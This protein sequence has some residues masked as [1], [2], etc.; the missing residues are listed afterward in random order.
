MR[1]LLPDSQAAHTASPAK[2]WAP[3]TLHCAMWLG[4]PWCPQAHVAGCPQDNA[5]RGSAGGIVFAHAR[6][7][8][9]GVGVAVLVFLALLLGVAAGGDGPCPLAR[10]DCR[11]ERVT[12]DFAATCFFLGGIGG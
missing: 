10:T 7:V 5:P 11:V 4:G 9:L 3:M 12:T 1:S 2:N 8:S 6:A